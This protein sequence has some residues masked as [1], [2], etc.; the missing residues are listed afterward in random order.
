MNTD[1][2]HAKNIH[3]LRMKVR[4]VD[5]PKVLKQKKR[6]VGKH[7]FKNWRLKAHELNSSVTN[8]SN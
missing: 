8:C 2:L 3:F 1:E 7:C 6:R 4:V 5:N